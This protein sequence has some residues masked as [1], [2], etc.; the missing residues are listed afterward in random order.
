MCSQPA[1]TFLKK[2]KKNYK[3]L[4][5]L[6]YTSRSISASRARAGDTLMLGV[7]FFPQPL[8]NKSFFC[9]MELFRL[10]GNPGI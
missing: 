7:H 2:Y 10:H 1:R 5:V 9:D 8:L 4:I 3:T 6:V